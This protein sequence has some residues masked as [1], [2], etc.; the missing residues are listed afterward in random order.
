MFWREIPKDGEITP[1]HVAAMYNVPRVN[2]GAVHVVE[3]HQFRSQRVRTISF[4]VSVHVSES[5]NLAPTGRIFI[6]FHTLGFLEN[7]SRKIGILLK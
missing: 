1:K 4:D 7:L 2:D 5:S 6:K 3:I